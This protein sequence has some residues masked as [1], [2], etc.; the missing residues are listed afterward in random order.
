MSG[1]TW[2]KFFW[3]DWE[4]DPAL[5]HCSLA[6][7]GLWMRMLCIAASHDPIGY[8]AV[9]GLALDETSIAR[10]TGAG[11]SEVRALLGELDRNGVYSRDRQGRIYSRRLTKD[12]RLAA[13]ARKNGK[14]G[15]NP[16]LGKGKGKTR[17]VNLKDNPRLKAQEPRAST[18]VEGPNSPSNLSEAKNDF[19]GP[20]E[21]RDAFVT[22]KGEAW[23][24]SYLDRCGW[25][26]VP[27]R[28]LIPASQIGREKITRECRAVLLAL[29]LSVIERAA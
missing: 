26:D 2:S 20:K 21:V 25:Q 18:K 1:L 23:C 5:R 29:G 24:V 7:Q 28:A 11:E 10:M 12:A 6:A 9:A 16:S 4:S 22:A 14:L 3:S 19:I 8:V 13:E 15:G 27:D 17:G